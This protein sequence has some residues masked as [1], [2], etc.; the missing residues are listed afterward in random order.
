MMQ[1]YHSNRAE[2]LVE[3]LVQIVSLPAADPLA[4]ETVVVQNPGMA[5]W[6]AQELALRTG[7]AANL[8]FP[9]P[10]SFAWR[11]QTAWLPSWPQED[12][13]DRE[14]LHWRILGLLPRFLARPAFADLAR[15]L[16]DD[17]SGLKA[18]Q[19]AGRIAEVFDQY[20]VYRPEMVL[21][22]E[23][24][25]DSDWQAVLWRELAADARSPHRAAILAAFQAALERGEK[26]RDGL[27]RRV[28]CF[29]LTALAP[30]H[31]RILEALS[32]HAEVHFFL[33]NPSAEYW[34]DI[35]D[36]R[37]QARRRA[38]WRRD[39][40]RD[41]SGLLDVGNPLLASLGHTGQ[42]FLDQLLD[43]GAQDHDLFE[44]PGEATLLAAVQRDI[45]YLRDRRA[46]PTVLEAGEASIQIHACHTPMR[47]VQVLRD[48]LLALFEVLPDLQPRQIVVMAPDI[49]VYAPHV[50]AVF[51]GAPKET[52]IPWTIADRRLPTAQPILETLLGLLDLPAWRLTASEVF[53][54]LELPAVSGRFGVDAQGLERIRTWIAQTQIRWGAD[55]AMRAAEGLPDE[56]AN[57]W[58]AG[59]GR[60]FLG[61]A[62]APEEIF[63]AE[64]LSCPEVEG[65]AAADLGALQTLVDRLT[66]WRTDLC[67]PAAA[68]A[69]LERVNRLVA[70][71]LAPDDEE[72][73]PLQAVRR[74]LDDLAR[75]EAAAGLVAP[76]ET[77][78]VRA[79]LETRLTAAGGA[80]RFL[81]GGVTFCNMVPMRAI[82]FRVVCLL[83][84]NDTDFPRHP[85]PAGFDRMAAAPRPGDRS[86]R[87]DDRYLFLEALL[88]ARDVFYLSYL[89][90]HPR[91]NSPRVP[92]TV[93]SELIDYVDR[94]WKRTDGEPP[95][96][97][98]VCR[99]PL[100]PFSRRLYDG[101][102]PALFSYDRSWLETAA[103]APETGQRPFLDQDPP[104]CE[105]AELV[106]DLEDLTGF[107]L[108]PAG[109]FLHQRLGIRP[110]ANLGA[111]ADEEPFDLD[112]L[113][114]YSARREL[115]SALVE[116]QDPDL[117]A[118]RV[119]AR[120]Q[121]PHGRVGQAAWADSQ[122]EVAPLAETVRGVR[123]R[124]LG[125]VE[126]DLALGPFTLRGWIQDL[127]DRG[128]LAA[129]PARINAKDRLRLWIRHLALCVAAPAGAVLESRHVGLG[130]I[131]RF[132]P[133]R[134]AATRLEALLAFRRRGLS[135]PPP[136]FPE[137]SWAYAS[138][139]RR[140]G[141]EAEAIRACRKA[142]HDA[143]HERGEGLAP[144]A[145]TVWRGRD[146]LGPAFAETAREIF[147]PLLAAA[148]PPEAS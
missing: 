4:P 136:F 74:I 7:I 17:E 90:N 110:E 5:R 119:R 115:M 134:D 73:E 86:R 133:T 37:G 52:H 114:R 118:R 66:Q 77:R 15:Y 45:L 6:L 123:G 71:F 104:L 143:Y 35:V 102:D 138:T 16:Q 23:A 13:Y 137:T 108:D 18:Y 101:T 83:G 112:G 57:T 117:I 103:A 81:L 31:L 111:P 19:L 33:L 72:A 135:S 139:L 105:E 59:L 127:T 60:L 70:D 144:A 49:E 34:T 14:R 46:S 38:R 92:A 55:S 63:F 10:A 56:A 145:Q 88:S 67:R 48:R 9:L 42:G 21:D 94:S 120:G 24:G 106:V 1:I 148:D 3:R 125:P 78:V 109:R 44:D 93:V 147:D 96:A 113:E 12:G 140:T 47:E 51:E 95:S 58:K 2:R 61:Y 99:H 20:L 82:P 107:F 8:E 22:W 64:T 32:R 43:L 68:G 98:L 69:W 116:G 30:V 80:R 124:G 85:H 97:R 87:L 122:K 76:L 91:D 141:K 142:W 65:A 25:R 29:G 89:G 84:L 40:T 28:C 27:P 100:Q 54:L 146:A 36:E 129:R 11:V 53:G 132:A 79:H 131:L 26:P 121:L 41:L 39:G 126:L 128:L 62:M 75:T 50:E 130:E